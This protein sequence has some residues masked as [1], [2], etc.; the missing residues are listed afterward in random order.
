MLDTVKKHAIYD[1]VAYHTGLEGVWEQQSGKNLPA[2]TGPHFSLKILYPPVPIQRKGSTQRLGS[3]GR[4][5][6]GTRVSTMLRITVYDSNASCSTIND[7]R[8][9]HDTINAA[10]VA[11]HGVEFTFDSTF[12]FPEYNSANAYDVKISF[13]ETQPDQ[14]REGETADTYV[15]EITIEGTISPTDDDTDDIVREWFIPE[16]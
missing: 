9:F 12:A 11:A 16:E 13:V 4:D 10:R 8:A 1:A 7:S 5:Q 6:R 15:E 14:N 2:M 3:E